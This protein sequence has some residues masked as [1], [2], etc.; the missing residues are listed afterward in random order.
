VQALITRRVSAQGERSQPL[1][2]CG[3]MAEDTGVA[4]TVF[5]SETSA[6]TGLICRSIR[7]ENITGL[8]HV[9]RKSDRVKRRAVDVV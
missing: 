3:S 5:R 7:A 1:G 9:E 4:A 8:R 6:R 2:M